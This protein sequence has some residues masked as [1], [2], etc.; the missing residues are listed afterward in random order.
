M[1]ARVLTL[2]FDERLGGF[3]DEPLRAFVKDRQVCAIR[4]HFFV[5]DSTPY[6]AVVVTYRVAPPPEM[7]TASEAEPKQ[8]SASWRDLLDP[9]DYPLFN[10]LRDWRM[11][12]SKEDGVPPY[13]ICTNKELAALVKARPQ[14]LAH[15]GEVRGFGKAKTEKYGKDLLALLAASEP[16]VGSSENGE[17][18][19]ATDSG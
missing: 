19:G 3:D 17:V 8:K 18:H 16:P 9:E 7:H 5:K 14:R 13:I 4:D 2:R 1:L 12:R 10:T 11:E 6:L 15:L